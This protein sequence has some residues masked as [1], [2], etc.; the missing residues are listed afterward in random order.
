[1]TGMITMN[2]PSISWNS[3][4][5]RTYSTTLAYLNDCLQRTRL[6]PDWLDALNDRASH[7]KWPR[8]R[9]RLLRTRTTRAAEAL[10]G[11]RASFRRDATAGRLHTPITNLPSY[12]RSCLRLDGSNDLV[13]LDIHTCQPYLI[14]KLARDVEVHPGRHPR[15]G[16]RRLLSPDVE[17][18]EWMGKEIGLSRQEAKGA[19]IK[20]LFQ[21]NWVKSAS[22]N[23]FQARFPAIAQLLFVMKLG[24]H[25]GLA[26]ALQAYEAHAI[27]ELVSTRFAKEEI[28]LLTIHDSVIVPAN[29]EQRATAIIREELTA[30]VGTEPRIK[31]AGL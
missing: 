6:S 31:S 10:A 18:H 27:I 9:L 8:K 2:H 28:P 3:V 5:L 29:H 12:L 26:E 25:R 19:F 21:I 17:V 22:K 14:L 7:E 15:M 16:G 4:G 30:F 11:G 1:M 23:L 20:M 13:H 24:D